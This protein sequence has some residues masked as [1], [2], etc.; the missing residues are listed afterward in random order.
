MRR[1]NRTKRNTLP[2]RGQQLYCHCGRPAVLRS[3]EG[4]CRTHW[5][6]AMAFVCSNYPACDSYTMAH[7]TTGEPMGSLA[8]PELRRLRAQ[9]H[10]RMERIQQSGLMTKREAYEWLAYT[11]QAPMAHAHIGHL[12]EYHC[13]MLIQESE[14]LLAS[15]QAPHMKPITYR[16]GGRRNVGAYALAATAG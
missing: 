2:A 4:L 6:G 3:A 16:K 5:E 8:G 9:A 13:R 15:R 12:S 7:P 11:V 10:K 14:K 1:T